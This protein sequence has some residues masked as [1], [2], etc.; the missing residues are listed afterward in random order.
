MYLFIVYRYV[1]LGMEVISHSEVTHT[2]LFT[3]IEL[4]EDFDGSVEAGFLAHG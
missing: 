1:F 3:I 4:F 2:E